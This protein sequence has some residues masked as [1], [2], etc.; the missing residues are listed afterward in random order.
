MSEVAVTVRFTTPDLEH[1]LRRFLRKE[2]SETEAL[3]HCLLLP[4][5]KGGQLIQFGGIIGNLLEEVLAL[6]AWSDK[7][8]I[9]TEAWW[10]FV[11]HWW[12]VV[13]GR[14][15][16]DWPGFTDWHQEE[17]LTHG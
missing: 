3:A 7:Y 5:D 10:F 12:C 8:H 15:A 14:D 2:G 9:P 11:A 16:H 13:L 4:D 1:L 6:K 17:G